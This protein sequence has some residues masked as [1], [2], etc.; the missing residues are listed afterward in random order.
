MVVM[1][2]NL[3]ANRVLSRWRPERSCGDGCARRSPS[4]PVRRLAELGEDVFHK[5]A[6]GR[7]GEDPVSHLT[8]R[9]EHGGVVAA[10]ESLSDRGKGEVGELAAEV[11]RHLASINNLAAA[12]G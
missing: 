1:L 3:C 8:V 6:R 5:L 7:V 12:F 4:G 11:H 2:W 10:S 9:M